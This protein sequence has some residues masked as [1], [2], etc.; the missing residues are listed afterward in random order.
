VTLGLVVRLAARNLVRYR[1]RTLLLVLAISCAVAGVTFLIALLRGMQ[2]DMRDA[3]IANLTGDVKV[4]A[5][6][7]RDDPG[8]EHRFVPGPEWTAAATEAGI[9][10]WA[11]RVRVPA[12][13]MSERE[14]RGITL[15]GVD[16]AREAISFLATVPVDGARLESA[17]D[18]RV[19]IGRALAR[20]LETRAGYRLVV[21]TQGADGRTRETGYRIAGVYDAEGEGLEKTF[22]FTGIGALQVRLDADGVTE[23]SIRLAESPDRPSPRDAQ[24]VSG[25]VERLADEFT[26][27]D[28]LRWQDLE[29]QA[30]GMLAFADSAVYIWFAII[31]GALVFGLLNALIAAVLERVRE[32]GLLRAIGMRPGTILLQVVFESV[33]LMLLGLAAGVALGLFLVTLAAPGID[34]SQWAAGVELSGIRT[35]LV[36]RLYG[37]DVLLVVGL[38]LCL[39]LAASVYPAW[40][41]IR[42]KPLEALG[43]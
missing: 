30:A 23:L 15:V 39:G 2:H 9:A 41:A 26:G 35:N 7:Y 1:R 12:V 6:G 25:L 22:V 10:G 14:T 33:L 43:R 34:L 38:S 32:F 24:F 27:L 13:I 42:L 21:I 19:L 36:P 28:V 18:A 8:I 29:P 37:A 3:V 11:P 40:R 4:L 16:P 31:M 5:P 17:E 20:Q